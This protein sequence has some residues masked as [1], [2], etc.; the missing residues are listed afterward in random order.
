MRIPA[1]C[2]GVGWPLS[3]GLISLRAVP[4]IIVTQRLGPIIKNGRSVVSHKAMSHVTQCLRKA[5]R[6]GSKGSKQRS[7]EYKEPLL[8]GRHNLLCDCQDLSEGESAKFVLT[9]NG[10]EKVPVGVWPIRWLGHWETQEPT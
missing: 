5:S 4:V 8:C 9:L 2:T 7:P 1:S 10:M 3:I 6:G